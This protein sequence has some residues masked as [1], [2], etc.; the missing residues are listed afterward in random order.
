MKFKEL[1]ILYFI[2]CFCKFIRS[3]EK[4]ILISQ[5]HSGTQAGL[6]GW[7]CDVSLIS[8]ET[9]DL[10]QSFY[11]HPLFLSLRWV[12]SSQFS[13]S[14]LPQIWSTPKCLGFYS[15]TPPCSHSHSVSVGPL[16][17]ILPPGSPPS[18]LLPSTAGGG[19]PCRDTSPCCCLPRPSKR[20][21]PSRPTYW[22]GPLLGLDS[23]RN[24][25]QPNVWAQCLV[26]K[27]S[28]LDQRLP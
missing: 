1:S 26:D 7:R 17:H 27:T 6:A 20:P 14:S 4:F 2:S 12:P 19:P 23:D 3:G 10:I 16:W 15:R 11:L 28:Q 9:P 13:F 24:Q 21:V 25:R 18:G 8:N 5:H 22:S